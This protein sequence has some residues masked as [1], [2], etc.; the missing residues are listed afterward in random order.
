MTRSFGESLHP[1]EKIIK[2]IDN[3]INNIFEDP[4]MLTPLKLLNR[5]KVLE[6][7]KIIIQY[8]TKHSVQLSEKFRNNKL[9]KLKKTR[10][11]RIQCVKSA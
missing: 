9:D 8:F 5:T 1:Y 10:T 6:I 3:D 4:I 2:V 7:I 11:S